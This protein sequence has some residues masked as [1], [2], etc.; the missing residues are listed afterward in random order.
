MKKNPQSDFQMSEA[1][2]FDPVQFVQSKMLEK[3]GGKE[4]HPQNYNFNIFTF[5]HPV[6]VI[7]RPLLASKTRNPS[8]VSNTPNMERQLGIENPKDK[9]WCMFRKTK[10]K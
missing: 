2:H 8:L 4:K 1:K 6:L 10:N 7:L 9:H 5:K 3:K